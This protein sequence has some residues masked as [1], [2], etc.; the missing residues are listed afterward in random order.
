MTKNRLM[1]LVMRVVG[2]GGAALLSFLIAKLTTSSFLGE[3]QYYLTITLGLAILARTGL[4]RGIVRYVAKT[5]IEKEQNFLLRYAL[6]KTV[7]TSA[8]LLIIC[9]LIIYLLY[10]N[11]V[12]FGFSVLIL[13]AFPLLAISIVFSGFYKGI[14]K[15]NISFLYDMGFTSLLTSILI[16][17]FCIFSKNYI[18]FIPL[19]FL[20]ACIST[21]IS[22]LLLL[23]KKLIVVKGGLDVIN[24][25]SSSSYNFMW[26]TLC[27][28]LQQLVLV[29]VI[30]HYLSNHELGLY[31]LA[32][33]LAFIVGFF[34]SVVTAIYSPY[35]SKIHE[36]GNIN[37]L[38]DYVRKA[39]N[40]SLIL[41]LPSFLLITLGSIQILNLFGEEYKSANLILIILALS[42]FINV[43]MGPASMV[44]NQS[45]YENISKNIVIFSSL[46]SL[47][48][49]FLACYFYGAL[50][51]AVMT[52]FITF[53]QNL[54]CYIY[55]YR[56][57]GII[58][59]PKFQIKR[60]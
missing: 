29:I 32:E 1:P 4:D 51:G 48:F 58:V 9:T 3:F 42:Q 11:K 41:S 37:K 56:K 43:I 45:G 23:K 38:E 6:L 22:G 28:Y 13:S 57:L 20:V 12:N 55:V 47:P 5:S 36:Q 35:F 17:V 39:S 40:M 46:L 33:K 14:F 21:N 26:M 60:I 16:I 7:R 59:Y 49:I 50:G 54:F 2:A 19:S 25:L 18:L 31:K 34:Q 53:M 24:E 15:P 30:S 27:V 44:L 8:L 52:L 10:Y